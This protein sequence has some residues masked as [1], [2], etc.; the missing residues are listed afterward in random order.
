MNVRADLSAITAVAKILMSD[1]KEERLTQALGLAFEQLAHD[2]DLA[3]VS[4]TGI[5][6][7]PDRRHIKVMWVGP[8]DADEAAV[9]E[10]LEGVRPRLENEAESM[11]RR[12]PKIRFVMDAGAVNQRRV[13]EILE[14]LKKPEGD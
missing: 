4:L 3:S 1:Y 9:E 5:E 14:D 10:A 6:L 8:D 12:R 7:S 11:L 13:E 2:D